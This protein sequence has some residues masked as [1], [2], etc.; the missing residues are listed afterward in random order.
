MHILFLVFLW[1]TQTNTLVYSPCLN[2][3][4]NRLSELPASGF[5]S[6]QAHCTVAARLFCIVL[7][8]SNI[9]LVICLFINFQ[10]LPAAAG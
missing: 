3:R 9:H 10:W 2:Y 7:F 4:T 8:T 5:S 1:R 6:S